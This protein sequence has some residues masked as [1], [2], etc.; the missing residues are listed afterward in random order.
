MR[1]QRITLLDECFQP[2]PLRRHHLGFGVRHE[3]LVRE[4][5]LF[6]DDLFLDVGK[7]LLRTVTVGL[8]IADV[9]YKNA[10][11]AYRYACGV[12]GTRGACHD[13]EGADPGQVLHDVGLALE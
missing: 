10:K 1:R 7:C 3:L 11:S 13:R 4:L 9:V 8:V 6:A 12:R 5:L 2:C